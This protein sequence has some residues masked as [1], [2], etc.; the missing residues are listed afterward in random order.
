MKKIKLLILGITVLAFNGCYDPP[1][2]DMQGLDYDSLDELVNTSDRVLILK[3]L[4]NELNFIVEEEEYL[5]FK[6]SVIEK[7]KGSSSEGDEIFITFLKSELDD[8]FVLDKRLKKF[9]QS[10]DDQE[11]LLFLIG[12]ARKNIFP[13]ELGGSLW[14]KNGNPSIFELRKDSIGIISKEILL[15]SQNKSFLEILEMP[16]TKFLS[17]VRSLNE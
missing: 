9:D 14:F 12:R 13:K 7:I 1:A 4:E 6:F 3:K 16:E 10:F 5:R 15:Q 17:L 11:Y 8:L 2:R